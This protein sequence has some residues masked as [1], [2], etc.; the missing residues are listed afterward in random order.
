[1]QYC[2][3]SQIGR[4]GKGDAEICEKYPGGEEDLVV[5]VNDPVAF[6]RW[7]LGEIEWVAVLRS[8]AIKIIGPRTL[9]RALPTWTNS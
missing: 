8:D 3:P 1:V 5:V 7:H 6:A 4:H 2:W 9:A